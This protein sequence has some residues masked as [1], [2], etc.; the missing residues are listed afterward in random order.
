[1]SGSGIHSSGEE[2]TLIERTYLGDH[3]EDSIVESQKQVDLVQANL[4]VAI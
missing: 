2:I 1:M 3:L 4:K